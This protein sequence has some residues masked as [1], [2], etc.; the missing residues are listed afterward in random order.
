MSTAVAAAPTASVDETTIYASRAYRWRISLTAVSLLA[1]LAVTLLSGPMPVHSFWTSTTLV[2]LSWITLALGL[3]I[4]LWG[5]T[6]IAGRKG[7]QVV[8]EGPYALC[9]NPLYWGTFLIAVSMTLF[10]Q[11]GAFAVS[12]IPPVLLYLFGVVPAEERFLR[13][14]LGRDYTK[15]C[16]ETPRWLPRWSGGALL[17]TSPASLGSSPASLGAWHAECR[18]QL[19]WLLLPLLAYAICVTR[20]LTWWPQ[21]YFFS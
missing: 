10:L 12:L 4:R 8:C 3:A 19:V 14:R 18:R 6:A 5:T 20:N 21:S 7:S 16:E 17:R 15:Y 9:R 11:S 13:H 2:V 1:G